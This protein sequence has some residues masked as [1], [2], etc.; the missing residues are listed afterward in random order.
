MIDKKILSACKKHENFNKIIHLIKKEN[1][2]KDANSIVESILDYHEKYKSDMTQDDLLL[3]HS[4]KFPALPEST[5]NR[6]HEDIKSI[7]TIDVNDK[8]LIDLANSFWKRIKAKNIG[9]KALEVYMG[10]N[11]DL[12]V[13][14]REVEDL[15][16]NES[17]TEVS[18]RVVD[19]GVEEL[20]EQE[21]L[22]CD[23]LFPPRLRENVDGVD[24]QT[25]GIIFARPE[26]GKTSF[27]C[28]LAAHY[29]E[30][31]RNVVYW[32]N[33]EK[34]ERVKIRLIQS[35]MNKTKSEL[36]EDI[37]NAGDVYRNSIKSKLTVLDSVGTSIREIDDYACRNDVDIMFIDQLDK[38]RIEGEFTRGDERL[39]E[40]YTRAREVAKRNNIVVWSVSQA[41]Y[42]AQ[43]R[44]EIDYSML[45]NSRTGKAGEADIIVGIGI[46]EEE[47]YRTVKFSKNKV[48]GWHGSVVMYLDKDRGTYT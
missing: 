2:P 48:N 21:F 25:F 16:E 36:R 42:E 17:N 4:E 18:Y 38:V 31:G 39:K 10:E 3:M 6:I 7:C 1:F 15:K 22:E 26:V 34:A 27:S 12:G 37:D 46:A 28:W 33:E 5:R 45:D 35:Y 30:Q 32:A 29:I 24:M 23:F 9:E 20:V 41:S 44:A 40:L 13:L 14:F 43:N 11:E 47:N 19:A 8:L